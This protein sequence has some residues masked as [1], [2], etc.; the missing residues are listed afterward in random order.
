ML[1]RSPVFT[2]IW[3][4]A[5]TVTLL[6]LPPLPLV[7]ASTVMER[8]RHQ[9]DSLVNGYQHQRHHPARPVDMAD[10]GAS[11]DLSVHQRATRDGTDWLGGAQEHSSPQQ[12]PSEV[13]A[14]GDGEVA[15][16]HCRAHNPRWSGPCDAPGS[17]CTAVRGD[18]GHRFGGQSMLRGPALQISISSTSQSQPIPARR[19]GGSPASAPRCSCGWTQE[20]SRRS[21]HSTQYW[22]GRIAVD[23][24]D[25]HR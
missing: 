21:A 1:S 18:Q 7:G 15:C 10:N 25:K 12:L 5:S 22:G 16:L 3:P 19:G 20:S 8:E 4:V 13:Q 2:S 23:G 17:R 24:L 6:H 9:N 14:G 11:S